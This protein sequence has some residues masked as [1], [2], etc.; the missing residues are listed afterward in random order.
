VARAEFEAGA[1]LGSVIASHPDSVWAWAARG[2]ELLAAADPVGAYAHASTGWSLWLSASPGGG[3]ESGRGVPDGALL[4]VSLL[5][6]AAAELSLTQPLDRARDFLA[7][8]GLR[9]EEPEL[10]ARLTR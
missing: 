9:L 2:A 3:A 5:G 4:A 6:L 7:D 8:Q 1:D 10:L